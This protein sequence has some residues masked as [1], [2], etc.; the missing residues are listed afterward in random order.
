MKKIWLR[1]FGLASVV[2]CLVADARADLKVRLRSVADGKTVNETVLYFK[3][4]RQRNE[5]TRLDGDKR[6]SLGTVIFQCDL[7]RYVWLDDEEKQFWATPYESPDLL[8][9][10]PESPLPSVGEER[11][12]GGVLTETFTVTDTGERREMFGYTARHIRTTRAW[13]AAPACRQ[14][15]LRRETDGW[16]IDLLYGFG[17]SPNLSGTHQ[18]SVTYP[19]TGCLR[20]YRQRY[21]RF[22]RTQ[23]GTAR[24]GF[25]VSEKITN[26]DDKGR[27]STL[28][29]EILEFSEGELDAVI[30]TTPETYR[31]APPPGAEKSVVSR[32]LSLLPWR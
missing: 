5:L 31:Q 18:H 8:A 16:Y 22:A 10:L 32:L 29:W 1:L 15:P 12:P 13:E 4:A 2:L 20:R 17:C 6:E 9:L 26:Y 14:T 25:P 3:G 30:F 27:P 28:T 23:Q 7:N 24:P 11:R 21:Y 19:E